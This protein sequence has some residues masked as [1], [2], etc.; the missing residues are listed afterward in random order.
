LEASEPAA[1]VSDGLDFVLCLL[2]KS[3]DMSQ[4]RET[5]WRVRLSKVM[6]AP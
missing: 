4:G 1:V 5:A 2:D 6:A 3:L